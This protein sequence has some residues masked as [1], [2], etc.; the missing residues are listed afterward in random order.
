MVDIPNLVYHNIMGLEHAPTRVQ[1]GYLYTHVHH[2]VHT[3][4][5]G[6]ITNTAQLGCI[7]IF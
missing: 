7:I 2:N 5:E 6:T 3:G 4:Y 1:L